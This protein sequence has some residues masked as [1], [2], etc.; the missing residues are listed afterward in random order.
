MLSCALSTS[1]FGSGGPGLVSSAAAATDE[2]KA[3][4]RALA[5]QAIDAFNKGRFEQAVDLL[6]RAETLV[7]SPGHW[8]YM[9]RAYAKLGRLVL[10]QEAL[11]KAE[12]E[13]LSDASPE[14]FRA[15]VAE[16]STELEALRPRIARVTV[17]IQ[18]VQ[19]DA[20]T[21]TVDGAAVPSALVG[22]PMPVDPGE[23]HFRASAP[24]MLPA[25]DNLTVA[26]GANTQL[27]LTLRPDASAQGAA[28]RPTDTPPP[29]PPVA[30]DS[31][32]A[33]YLYGGIGATVLGAGALVGGYFNYQ[34]GNP[35]RDQADAL[36]AACNPNKNC[37]ETG[38]GKII[39]DLDD[40]AKGRWYTGIGLM[41]LGGV[42][43]AG[44][45]TLIVLSFQDPSG[46]TAWTLSPWATANSVGLN[47]T[48]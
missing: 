43:V 11:L 36:F 19:R 8:L 29:P 24:G 14:A 48:F 31:S 6:R 3:G 1:W 25:S 39:D 42:L 41:S 46:E 35:R 27:T 33:L 40:R 28:S 4:A 9:G 22:V 12:R 21:V 10:A 45:V 37:E 26:E 23:R 47:G 18:G 15:A 7:H 2:E 34:K 20:A 17:D 13:P 44:G 5:E 32:R 38:Q 16:A 30:D